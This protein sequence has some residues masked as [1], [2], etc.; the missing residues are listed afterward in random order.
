MKPSDLNHPPA[1]SA[2][3]DVPWDP[4]LCQDL[5]HRLWALREQL[6]A[7]EQRFANAIARVGPHQQPS[8][9]NLVHYLALRAHDLRPLQQQL[10]WLGLSSLGRAESH[11]L[12]NLDKVLG[13]LHRL[14]GRPWHDRSAEEPLGS[15]RG[16]QLLQAHS[17]ALL[18]SVQRERAV[19]IMVTLPSEAATDGA[20]VRGL[21]AA[22]MDV[23]RINCAHDNAAAWTAMAGQVRKAARAAQ[24]E[25]KILMDLGGPKIRTGPLPPGPAVVRL[26]PVRDALGFAVQ[27]ARLRLVPEGTPVQPDGAQACVLVDREWLKRL[28]VGTQIELIDARGK[29]RR[30]LVVEAGS[31]GALADTLQTCYLT[32]DVALTVKGTNG[33][34]RHATYPAGIDPLPGALHLHRGDVLHLLGDEGAASDAPADEAPQQIAC[35]LP[36]VLAQ[37]RVGERVWL[38]D[39][40]IGGVV[41]H[42]TPQRLEVAIEQA[43]DRGERLL[44]DKGINFPDSTLSLPAVTDQDHRDLRTVAEVADLVGLSFVQAPG[45]VQQLLQTLHDLGGERVGVVL[46]IETLRGFENL[47]ELML[48]AMAAPSAG[49]M[50]ARGDLAVECGYER[51][52]EVQEEILWAAEAAHMPVIWATQVLDN[53][54][55]TGLPS[56]AE[57]SD[58]SMGVRAECVM[59]NKGPFITNAIRTLDDILRRM[60]GHQAKKAPLLRALRAWTTTAPPPPARPRRR[61]R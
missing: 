19:R 61:A 24:R 53:L 12:A 13:I 45:D 49:V 9:R 22:G 10:A 32:P 4:A 60:A 1:N 14:T 26:K 44:P 36:Q 20:L 6:L 3:G 42:A 57:I 30:L 11:V 28:R 38:D 40:R 41:R 58:A 7:S 46:K 50:I 55:R 31:R 39:G 37:V 33:R 5:I 34:K 48:A 29:P 8:A 56:R 43:R 51:M 15:V 2:D 54:A 59:L 23:A 17:Q 25:V 27:P 18:G 47:P 21:V 16:H 52:A 35:T